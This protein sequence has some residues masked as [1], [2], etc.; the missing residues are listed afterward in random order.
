MFD[1][2]EYDKQYYKKNKEKKLAYRK[3]YYKKNK[4]SIL[5]YCKEYLKQWK[6]NNPEYFKNYWRENKEKISEQQ[7]KW[8]I[9]N[10]EHKKKYKRKWNKTETGKANNQRGFV[11][12]QAK[13]RKII[14]TLTAEEWLDILKEYKYKCA[15]C[16][17]EFN[18]FDRPTRDHVI[19]IS[20]EGN[21]VKENIIPA[22]R[23]CNSKK[24]N[25]IIK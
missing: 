9:N 12:R 4:E 16:G 17:K 23:S 7:K 10:V 11:K 2:K 6:K 14:N 8:Y 5:G 18:L 3:Q 19:P 1:R 25:K 15:Y 21:N 13:L 22:C 24:N 20:K